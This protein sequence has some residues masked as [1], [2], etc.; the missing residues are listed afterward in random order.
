MRGWAC[1]KDCLDARYVVV[2]FWLSG[3]FK[4]QTESMSWKIKMA[5]K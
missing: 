5:E 4:M 3:T 1:L 2:R